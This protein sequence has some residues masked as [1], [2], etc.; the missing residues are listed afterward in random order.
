MLVALD[1]STD[2]GSVAI[3]RGGE[4]L[5][6][7]SIGMHARHAEALLPSL[8]F[9]LRH[10]RIERSAIRGVVVGNGPGSFT[11][12][13][14]A[15][16]TARGLALGLGVPLYA[17]ST[18]AALALDL[19]AVR[20]VCAL[21]DARRGEVYAASYSAGGECVQAE[22]VVRLDAFLAGLAGEVELVE[23]AGQPLARAIAHIARKRWE[24]GLATEAAVPE[25]NYIRP[26][27]VR[28]PL[29]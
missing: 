27:D 10:E 8:D 28:E 2:L 3:G 25:A 19:A 4:L 7:V 18:L 26:P 1:A 24:Q 13:R 12:V 16:A 15:A 17:F 14:I 23:R 9:L 21:L 6:E 22:C 20:P 11:G 29:R 5:G